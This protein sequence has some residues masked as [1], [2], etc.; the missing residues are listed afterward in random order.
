MEPSTLS[1]PQ[2]GNASFTIKFDACVPNAAETGD[3]WT[4]GLPPQATGSWPAG[5]NITNPAD[6]T[7]TWIRVDIAGETATYTLTEAGAAVNNLCFK[8][9]FGG[10]F[11]ATMEQGEHPVEVVI[12]LIANES[13]GAV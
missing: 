10:R 11:N 3:T 12:R 13:V 4:V 2:N 7:E 9:Q 6:P 1:I 5:F 8:S